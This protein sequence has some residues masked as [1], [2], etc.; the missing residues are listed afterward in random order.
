MSRDRDDER[1]ERPRRSWREIDQMRD[2]ASGRR[3]RDE[4]PRG[5]AAEARARGATQQYVRKLDALFS[6]S[7]G[8]AAGEEHAK[9]VRDAHGT[10]ELAAACRA[11]MAALGP[12]DDASLLSL[13]LDARDAALVAEVLEA[14]E[15]RVR[16]GSL[17]LAGGLRTQLR[18]LADDPDD[19]VAEL[20]ESLLRAS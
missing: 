19:R 12:P 5:P 9:A 20:A 3:D 6:R 13:F 10:P 2:R 8:G 1:D 17:V 4:R 15:E 18:M 16:A 7:K 11:Y 14:M